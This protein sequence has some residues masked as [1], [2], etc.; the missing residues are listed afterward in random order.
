MKTPIPID[1]MKQIKNIARAVRWAA[2][3][4]VMK[5]KYGDIYQDDPMG[6]Y[7]LG[8]ACGDCSRAIIDMI[9]RH[10]GKDFAI[11]QSGTYDPR[12]NQYF[13]NWLKLKNGMILDVTAT[14]FSTRL[15]KV[16]ITKRNDKYAVGYE[17][18]SAEWGGRS[19]WRNSLR[20]LAE[21][22]Y[23]ELS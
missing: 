10:V 20:K 18:S 6:G 1:K 9:R 4:L 19:S 11:W 12:G 17:G 2:E 13:H 7:R 14:Q 15:P 5:G 21:K 23:R 16:Y 22:K 3:L 8:G